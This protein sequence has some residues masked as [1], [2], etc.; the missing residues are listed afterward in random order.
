MTPQNDKLIYT[1]GASTRSPEEFIGLLKGHGIE[2]AVDVSEGYLI[3]GGV[4][5]GFALFSR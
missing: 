3:L 4:I 1:L 5:P 2:A